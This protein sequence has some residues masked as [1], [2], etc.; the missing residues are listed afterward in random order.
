M[1]EWILKE[2]FNRK[3]DCEKELRITNQGLGKWIVEKELGIWNYEK[4][5]MNYEER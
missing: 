5:I 4:R 2:K 3:M 1:K